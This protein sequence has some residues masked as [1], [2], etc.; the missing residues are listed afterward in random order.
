M[1]YII[2]ILGASFIII[3]FLTKKYP[4]LLS[5]YNTLPEEERE[6]IDVEKMTS[7]IRNTSVAI[8]IIL[9]FGALLLTYFGLSSYMDLFLLSVI[10]IGVAII[11]FNQ[12]KYQ[13]H[14]SKKNK[15]GIY[16]SIIII[17]IVVSNCIY[18][19]MPASISLTDKEL[20]I[21]GSYGQ[22]IPIEDIEGV[23]LRDD[24]PEIIKR[25][26][27]LS[28]W[29]FHKGHFRINEFGDAILYLNSRNAPYLILKLKT[30][31]TIILNRS[32]STETLDI[33]SRLKK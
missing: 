19:G 29:K 25:T 22:T 11:I 1:E 16:L 15:Y 3:G 17:L 23:E 31:K 14:I 24:L 8:G 9:I 30:Q 12:Y 18:A 27:G 26:N 7:S 6:K 2:Y 5:G 28:F 4:M 10:I 33:Y 21:K 20:V 32:D 13:R